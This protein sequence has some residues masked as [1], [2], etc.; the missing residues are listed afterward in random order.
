[1]RT[2]LP[3]LIGPTDI[4]AYALIANATEFPLPLL[5]QL[6]LMNFASFFV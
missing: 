6:A 4:K 2:I 1:M 3:F 5:T